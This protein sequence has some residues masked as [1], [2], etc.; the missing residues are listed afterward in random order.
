MKTH[1]LAA[2]GVLFGALFGAPLATTGAQ[3]AVVYSNNFESNATGF[4]GAGSLQTTGGLSAFGFG[5][6]HLRND[7]TAATTLS[8]AGLAAHTTLTFSFDLAMWDSIDLGSDTFEIKVDGITVF[9]TST[10]FGNYFPADNVG[11]G[12]GTQITPAF[13]AFAVPDYG[14]GG[15]RDSARSAS[16]TLNHSSATAAISFQF[17]NSQGGSD[18]S[19]GIDNMAVSTNAANTVPEPG[20]IALVLTAGLLALRVR[21]S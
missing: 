3:A 17:P 11:R 16:F 21:R 2:T 7:G 19:F 10:E 15:N 18:E 4:G 14:F 8:L 1:L 9:S 20:S 13:T 5:Q 12:P 6:Q